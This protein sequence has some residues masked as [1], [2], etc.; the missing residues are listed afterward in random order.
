MPRTDAQR[1]AYAA[2]VPQT[3]FAEPPMFIE[4]A[5]VGAQL[6]FAGLGLLLDYSYS[7]WG[8]DGQL[9]RG[10]VVRRKVVGSGVLIGSSWSWR[11]NAMEVIRESDDNAGDG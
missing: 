9:Y 4:E 5:L 1:R 7:F 10:G 2:N 11:A 3:R 6:Y 8:I